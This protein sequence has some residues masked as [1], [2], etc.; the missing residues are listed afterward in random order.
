MNE[1]H[2]GIP[3]RDAVNETTFVYQK[4][5]LLVYVRSFRNSSMA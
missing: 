5:S 1:Y 3:K 2:F 4:G